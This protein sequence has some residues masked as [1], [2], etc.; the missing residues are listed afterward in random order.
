ML[1]LT[2]HYRKNA[3]P[4]IISLDITGNTTIEEIAE[5]AASKLAKGLK[6]YRPNISERSL[7]KFEFSQF[8]M[9]KMKLS[10]MKL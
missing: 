9:L 2:I 8:M 5:K 7:K 3:K 10:E 1:T 4:V 6:R